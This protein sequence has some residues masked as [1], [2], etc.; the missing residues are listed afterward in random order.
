MSIEQV[1][2]IADHLRIDLVAFPFS[3]LE[4]FSM[5]HLSVILSFILFSFNL[6]FFA[7]V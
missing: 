2:Y 6:N 7:C 3:T 4:G 5:L 1:Y